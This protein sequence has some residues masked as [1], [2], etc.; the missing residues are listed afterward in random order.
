ME[1]ISVF[2]S[3]ISNINCF[4]P[5]DLYWQLPSNRNHDIIQLL[6]RE[7]NLFRRKNDIKDSQNIIKGQVFSIYKW[8][9]FIILWWH[10]LIQLW[11]CQ[12]SL[13]SSCKIVTRGCYASFPSTGWLPQ[14]QAISKGKV[15]E[16][17]DDFKMQGQVKSKQSPTFTIVSRN[18]LPTICHSDSWF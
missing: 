8:L 1:T 16:P 5:V 10:E 12:N 18:I 9:F 4:S 11:Q 15:C 14:S 2:Y 13:E 6:E 7:R 3:E 17:K